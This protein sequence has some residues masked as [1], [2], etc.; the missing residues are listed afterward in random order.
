[1]T[2]IGEILNSVDINNLSSLISAVDNISA[3]NNYGQSANIYFLRNFTVE[4][5]DPYLKYYLFKLNLKPNIVFG[6]YDEMRQEIL[7]ENSNLHQ[8]RPHLIIL[9]L[10]LE[11]LDP[12]C[13]LPNWRSERVKDEIIKL[14]D[15]LASKSNSLIAVN[16]FV[17][18]FRPNTGIA[19]LPLLPKQEDEIDGLNTL[20]RQYVKAH[21]NQFILID[22]ERFIR[23]LG[24]EKSMDY[25]YWYT[26]RA[27]FKKE[28]NN[29][30]AQEIAKIIKA[31]KGYAKKCLVL[32]CDNTLWGGVIGEDGLSGIKLDKNDY[33][34]NAYYDF[35]MSILHLIE[36]GVLVAICSKN[37]EEDVWSVLDNHPYNLIKRSH[38]SGWRINWENKINNIVSLAGELNLG[39]DSF[40]FVDDSPTEC[41]LIKR[42]LPEITVLQ[43]PE[44]LYLYPQLLL[45][46]GLFDNLH[47][48]NE[49]QQRTALYQ[50]EVQRKQAKEQFKN[51]DDYLASLELMAAIHP[52]N[53]YEIPRVAQLTQKTNQFNLT[54][55]R[56]SEKE[57]RDLSLD[58]SWTIYSLSVKDKFGDYGLTGVIMVKHGGGEGMIDNFLLSCRILGRGLEHAFLSYCIKELETKKKVEHWLAEYIPTKKNQQAANF[59]DE[60]G[61]MKIE[62]EDGLKLYSMEKGKLRI[63]GKNYI[64]I[65]E[66]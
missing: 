4:G 35:Q 37:N 23:I 63:S 38:L 32:D 52:I 65:K 59:W 20:I 15:L 33:P 53:D 51:I 16:T 17:P 19:S 58:P 44:K 30:Y 43:V 5:I 31:L 56:Y 1:M 28:F 9:S 55:R 10:M 54:T 7:D 41:E 22:W 29:L 47:T 3:A 27:P 57:I 46:D 50:T 48:T 6:N 26:A 60:A 14:F 21:P 8:M 39:I 62:N 34:G 49:D 64:K 12:G 13:L 61:F 36:R 24:E 42:Y 66:G 18:P 25:R 45:K 2:S 40:V 11:Q